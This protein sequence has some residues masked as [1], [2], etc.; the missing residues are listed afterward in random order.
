MSNFTWCIIGMIAAVLV[1]IWRARIFNGALKVFFI[2]GAVAAFIFFLLGAI[3][4]YN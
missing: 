4:L 2:I 3:V 1:G